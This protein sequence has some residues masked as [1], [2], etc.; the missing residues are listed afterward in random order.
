MHIEF[1]L[2]GEPVEAEVDP[3]TPL[4]DVLREE[5]DK[6]GVKVGCL[7]GRCGVCTVHLEDT[8][9]KSCLVMAPKA[10]GKSVTTISGLADGEDGLHEVQEAFVDHFASQCGYCTPGFVMSAVDYLEDDP[11]GDRDDVRAALKGNVCRCTGYEKI[12]DAVED[13]ARSD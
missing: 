8:A 13:V 4:R 6:T 10:D 5:F 11:D 1:E 2:D 7:S 3:D 9:V 12:L